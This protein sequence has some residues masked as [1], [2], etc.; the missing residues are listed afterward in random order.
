MVKPESG[1]QSSDS[2]L[3]AGSDV[4]DNLDLPVVLIITYG[5]VAIAR[6]FLLTL[7]NRGGDVVAVEV[8]AGLRVN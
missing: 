5:K 8:S 7:R 4:L 3:I 6:N 1:S 2:A